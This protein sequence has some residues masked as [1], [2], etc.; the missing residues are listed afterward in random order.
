MFAWFATRPFAS[1]SVYHRKRDSIQQRALAHEDQ[2][3]RVMFAAGYGTFT[4][5]TYT[6]SPPSFT[7]AYTCTRTLYR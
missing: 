2:H 3:H 4:E 1:C 5:E 7:I 6:V